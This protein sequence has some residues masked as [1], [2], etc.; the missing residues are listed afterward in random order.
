[1]ISNPIWPIS[2]SFPRFIQKKNPLVGRSPRLIKKT[3]EIYGSPSISNQIWPKSSLVSSSTG[4]G[5]FQ[6]F[7]ECDDGINLYAD[8]DSTPSDWMRRCSYELG[9]PHNLH[10]RKFKRRS[11]IEIG[12]NFHPATTQWALIRNGFDEFYGSQESFYNNCSKSFPPV[13]PQPSRAMEELYLQHGASENGSMCEK[14]PLGKEGI[15]QS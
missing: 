4:S 1:M 13:L 7:I 3:S 8:L 14:K 15:D 12:V 2:L 10:K 9:L 6:F 11:S 5:T